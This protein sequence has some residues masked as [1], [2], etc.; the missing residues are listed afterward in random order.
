MAQRS[1][2]YKGVALVNTTLG[3]LMA[4]DRRVHRA[5]RHARH[6]PG[7]GLDLRPANSFYLLWMIL[8]FLV[9]TSVLVERLGWATCT[10]G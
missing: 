5:D 6:L 8:G 7:I 2:G 1:D 4:D 3:V 10:D 9:V